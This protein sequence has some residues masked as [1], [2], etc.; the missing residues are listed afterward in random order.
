MKW[1]L[2]EVYHWGVDF[3]GFRASPHF[4]FS[5]LLLLL[6]APALVSG[7]SAVSQQAATMLSLGI[8]TPPSLGW[9]LPFLK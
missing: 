5:L 7:L 2:E 9:A 4:L 8:A 6:L 3:S 1:S